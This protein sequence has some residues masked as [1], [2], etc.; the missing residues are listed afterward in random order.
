MRT[1]DDEEEQST[2]KKGGAMVT[3]TQQPAWMRLLLANCKEWLVALPS[4]CYPTTLARTLTNLS[5]ANNETATTIC[6]KP[7]PSPPILY[8]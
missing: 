3:T 2:E 7:R 4:V 8:A 1:L 6:R 5:A